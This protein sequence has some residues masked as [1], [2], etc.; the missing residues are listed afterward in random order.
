[1]RPDGD[2]GGE[3]DSESL[4]PDAKESADSEGSRDVCGVEMDVCG[5]SGGRVP[6]SA[7]EA[8]MSSADGSTAAA[9]E[10]EDEEDDEDRSCSEADESAEAT[11]CC[12]C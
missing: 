2:S 3:P 12:S 4:E 1:M 6:Q 5:V 11:N 9:A 8:A 7:E 10:D